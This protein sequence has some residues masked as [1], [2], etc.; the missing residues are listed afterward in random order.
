MAHEARVEHKQARLEAICREVVETLGYDLVL[1]KLK[2]GRKSVLRV[3]IDRRGGVDLDDC[4]RVSRLLGDTL[5]VED[6]IKGRYDL[7]VSSPGLDRTLVSER[8]FWRKVGKRASVTWRPNPASEESQ[9]VTGEILDAANGQ[10]RLAAGD[11]QE[12]IISLDAIVQAK[13]EL[14]LPKDGRRGVGN[15]H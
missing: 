12:L 1:L 11:D 6:L 5:D 15:G 8:D 2:K 14:Y 4:V 7:E 3:F 13:L 9:H 10:V